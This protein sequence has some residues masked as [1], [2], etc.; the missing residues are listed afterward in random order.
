MTVL[1]TRSLSHRFSDGTWG[2][3]DI[4][5][6]I[7]HREFL[8]IA[9]KNGSGKTVLMKHLNGL[10]K[11]SS[12]CVLL[13]GNDIFDDLAG[14]RRNVGLVFQNPDTQIVGQTVEEDVA[15]G[16]EN[17]GL[18]ARDI[19]E[20]VAKAL[21]F[22]GMEEFGSHRTHILSGGEKKR[23][24]IAGVLAMQPEILIL[25]EPFISLDYPGVKH[26]LESILSLHNSGHTI[27]VI[28]HDIGKIFPYT[29][30]TVIMDRGKVVYQ[31]APEHARTCFGRYGIREYTDYEMEAR[32]WRS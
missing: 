19:D 31:G 32:V 8:L 24:T 16:P 7:E 22:V 18:S 2:L 26:V 6:S 12:G 5:L 27:A 11:P 10:L 17:L 28:T 20:R 13:K 4:S 21:R 3:K 30:K 14:T 29:T 25:D 15:F 23:L 1:E 9:G